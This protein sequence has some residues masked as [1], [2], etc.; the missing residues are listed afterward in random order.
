MDAR[1]TAVPKI[2]L[3]LP[4]PDLLAYMREVVARTAVAKATPL[5][6]H[7]ECFR[8]APE[9]SIPLAAVTF[10]PFLDA[11]VQ[12]QQPL[13]AE[14]ALPDVSAWVSGGVR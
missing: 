1:A 7:E 5:T 13:L 4:Q 12:R 11:R 10:Q 9:Q 3:R 2:K 8:P 6:S 14:L